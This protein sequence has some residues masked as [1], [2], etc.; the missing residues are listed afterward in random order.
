MKS[1][2]GR[3]VFLFHFHRLSV[4]CLLLFGR[5]RFL[6]ARALVHKG[7]VVRAEL[8]SQLVGTRHAARGGERSRTGCAPH[9][10]VPVQPLIGVPLTDDSGVIG[11][12]LIDCASS[13]H[14]FPFSLCQ[15]LQCSS[16]LLTSKSAR[17]LHTYEYSR[18]AMSAQ[19][20]HAAHE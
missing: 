3:V 20:H 16:A 4:G 18:Q 14:Q 19:T 6:I 5:Q 2:L 10:L 17:V 7:F 13:S 9:R 1:G 15:R 8:V 12:S 11:H